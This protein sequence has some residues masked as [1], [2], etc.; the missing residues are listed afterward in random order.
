MSMLKGLTFTT[1]PRA[2]NLISPQEYRRAKLVAHLQEQK[3]IAMAD[4]EGREHTVMRRRWELTETGEKKRVEV[5]KRL[6]RWWM[7]DADG[8]VLLTLRWGS[9]LLAL[10]GDKTA[11][12]VGDFGKLVA[13][14]DKLT[15]AAQAGELDATM[16]RANKVRIAARG[17]AQ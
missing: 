5:S 8:K 17:S 16:E 1:A 4:A 7:T 6:K 9:Q 11:I 13:I 2:A 15:Y 14:L 10:Q 12:V 3:D